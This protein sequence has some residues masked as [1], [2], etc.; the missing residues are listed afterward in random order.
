M[1]DFGQNI[2]RT[3]ILK[4]LS[5]GNAELGEVFALILNDMV[6]QSGITNPEAEPFDIVSKSW[7]ELAGK[8]DK[9]KEDL[10]KLDSRFKNEVRHLAT[11]YLLF[12]AKETGNLTGKIDY[13]QYEA[14]QLKYRFGHYSIANNIEYVEKIKIQIRNAF[15][16]IAAHGEQTGGDNL[17]DK[18]DMAAYIYALAT[19][20][21]HDENDKFTGFEIDGIITPRNYAISERLLFMNEKDD[22]MSMKMR[23]GYKMLNQ[24]SEG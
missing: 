23:I 9:T 13:H 4:E 11:S 24:A 16:K 21:N 22:M 8:K 15:N 5:G 2:Q 17:I 20:T 10:E 7:R 19:K 18:H 12:M 6:V 1:G 3:S 14:Y